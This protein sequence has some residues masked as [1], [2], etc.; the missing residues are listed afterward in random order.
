M[1]ALSALLNAG[2][3]G[4][5]ILVDSFVVLKEAEFSLAS[6]SEPETVDKFTSFLSSIGLAFWIDFEIAK[7]LLN[8]GLIR[9]RSLRTKLSRHD[10]KRSVLLSMSVYNLLSS[11]LDPENTLKSIGSLKNI[12]SK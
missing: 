8:V 10:C 11:L 12:F 4:T 3:F 2:S 6:P 5:S 1:Q 9:F 7:S